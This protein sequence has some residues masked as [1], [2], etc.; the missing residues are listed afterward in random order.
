MTAESDSGFEL[1]LSRRLSKSRRDEV[2][3]VLVMSKSWGEL[4]FIWGRGGIES[5]DDCPVPSIVDG[6]P[7][8]EFMSR[9]E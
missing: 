6:A 4:M 3:L 7:E 5:R 1:P 2:E 8:D 9:K